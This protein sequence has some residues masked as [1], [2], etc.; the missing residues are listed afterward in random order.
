MK[1]LSKEEILKNKNNERARLYYKNNKE[2]VLKNA[3]LYTKEN[4]E[5][6]KEKDKK[7]SKVYRDN[8]KEKIMLKQKKY[9]AENKE[10]INES[11]KLYRENNK[12]LVKNSKKN[13]KIKKLKTDYFYR[14]KHNV[15]NLIRHA[16][17]AKQFVKGTKTEIILGCSY[18]EFKS[19][20]ESKFEPWM[21]WENYG[22]YNGQLNYG[23]DIDHIIPTSSAKSEEE[24]LKLNNYNNLQPLCSYFNRNI[25][26]NTINS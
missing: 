24:L 4:K 16:I 25:K 15:G 9:R 11:D 2:K 17:K 8:N 10:K 20:L 12:E 6:I 21:S 5:I 26:K 19:H 18:N 3:K 23:W 14:L 1:E 22:K 7:R 13:Y